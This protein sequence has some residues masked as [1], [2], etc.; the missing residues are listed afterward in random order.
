MATVSP[1]PKT[2][3]VDEADA[4]S[5]SSDLSSAPDSPDGWTQKSTAVHC[6]PWRSQQSA[7][8]QERARSAMH[9]EKQMTCLDCL[10]RYPKAVC[11]SML[12]I[13]TVIM[14]AYDKLLVTG[15]FALP[16]FS[17][18]FGEP[19]PASK[20]SA[21]AKFEISPTWQMALQNSSIV[22]EISGLLA[23]WLV[24]KATGYRPM[25]FVC[26]AWICVAVF[27]AVTAAN[28]GTLLASQVLLGKVCP[29]R[30]MSTL[31]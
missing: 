15:L 21:P 25:L 18:R 24:S 22:T 1:T 26:L 7:T 29:R 9:R 31:D 11:W 16:T 4:A 6:S 14:E 12:L 2:D 8:M 19:V 5:S 3:A 28:L 10:R 27:P 23:F 17:Q 20:A 30:L 13:A